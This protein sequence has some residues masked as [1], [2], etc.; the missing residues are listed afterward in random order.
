MAPKEDGGVG[1]LAQHYTRTE[2]V[3]PQ[4]DVLELPM[5]A[6][7]EAKAAQDEGHQLHAVFHV[8]LLA[9]RTKR[10]DEH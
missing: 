1:A 2:V 3:L 9:A 10:N 8:R 7:E 5:S 6:R 4:V